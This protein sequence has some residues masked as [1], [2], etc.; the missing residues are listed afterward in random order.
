VT[1]HDTF[2]L[3]HL[4]VVQYIDCDPDHDH[5]H[6]RD[7]DCC[8]ERASDLFLE[9]ED[10]LT[11]LYH[12]EAT[13]LKFVVSLSMFSIG[14]MLLKFHLHVATELERE[15]HSTQLSLKIEQC[16]H[17]KNIQRELLAMD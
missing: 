5:D 9:C 17:K 3:F 7:C 16:V 2:L 12:V 13:L 15:F 11:S 10:L 8:Y 14:H 6:D 4:H 1:C